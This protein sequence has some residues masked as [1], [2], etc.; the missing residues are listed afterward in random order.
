MQVPV[1]DGCNPRARNA[2]WTTQRGSKE[3][4][5]AIGTGQTLPAAEKRRAGDVREGGSW[6]VERME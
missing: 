5:A 1:D 2:A 6:R 3:Q 4:D